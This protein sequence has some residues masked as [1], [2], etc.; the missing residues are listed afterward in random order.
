M[1]PRPRL[2][3]RLSHAKRERNYNCECFFPSNPL[4]PHEIAID[5]L[6]YKHNVPCY[7]WIHLRPPYSS[8]LARKRSIAST[9]TTRCGFRKQKQKET[10]TL[11]AVLSLAATSSHNVIR[12]SIIYAMPKNAWMPSTEDTS[13]TDV[14][15]VCTRLCPTIRYR[16]HN[17]TSRIGPSWP[18]SPCQISHAWIT[19]E[20]YNST[21]SVAF[22]HL[23]MHC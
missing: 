11:H 14:R 21:W 4:H 6:H 20:D 9:S 3:A 12:Q 16:L 8:T 18:S 7:N 22:H 10:T 19:L 5:D 2:A 13:S 1:P 15:N 23:S 17:L